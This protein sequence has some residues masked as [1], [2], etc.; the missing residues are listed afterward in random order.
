MTDQKQKEISSHSMVASSL[1][2]W[3]ASRPPLYGISRYMRLLGRR[4][5]EFEDCID[6]AV[7]LVFCPRHTPP[8]SS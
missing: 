4:P 2:P 6:Y 5:H 1:S 8:C 3:P 7:G